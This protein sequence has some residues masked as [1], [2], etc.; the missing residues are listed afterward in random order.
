MTWI[1]PDFVEISLCMEVTG[2]VNTDDAV[3]S[4]PDPP[5]EKERRFSCLHNCMEFL[6]APSRE[7]I[8]Q[9]YQHEKKAKID[10]RKDLAERLGI[11]L[12]TLRM[13]A[14]RIKESLQKCV[15]EC[16]SREG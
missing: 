9:Y 8:L 4:P 11:S 7:L 1:K 15:R 5:E 2:Y 3:E 10:H 16:V 14:H 6:D 12:N 13:R